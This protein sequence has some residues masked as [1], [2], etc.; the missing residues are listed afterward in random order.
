MDARAEGMPGWTSSSLGVSVALFVTAGWKKA[1][2]W[3]RVSPAQ[4]VL[5]RLATVCTSAALARIRRAFSGLYFNRNPFAV[6]IRWRVGR[7]FACYAA[8]HFADFQDRGFIWRRHHSQPPRA[9]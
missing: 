5:V 9:A 8:G 7:L 6:V 1:T 4:V 3:L 2:A